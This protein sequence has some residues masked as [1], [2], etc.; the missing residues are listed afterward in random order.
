[1]EDLA[2]F[3]KLKFLF[4]GLFGLFIL[5]IVLAQMAANY[6]SSCAF[7][8]Q[9]PRLVRGF[10]LLVLLKGGVVILHNICTI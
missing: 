6:R 5:M 2:F 4:V 10:L 7:M 1:M 8:I 9:K 3:S